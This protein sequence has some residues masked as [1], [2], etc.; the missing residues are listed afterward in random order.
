[1][2]VNSTATVNCVEGVM[3]TGQRDM[4]RIRISKA[5]FEAGFRAKTP[6][7]RFCTL[8]IKNEFDCSSRQ[9]C[10]LHDR[11]LMRKSVPR[12]RHEAGYPGI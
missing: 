3:H 2:S 4:I 10:R 6:W 11:T 1:M 12:L 7:Q 9:M 8:N 5:T